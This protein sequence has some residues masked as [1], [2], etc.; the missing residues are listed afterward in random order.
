MITHLT[1]DRYRINKM[2]INTS[3]TFTRCNVNNI[4]FNKSVIHKHIK[5]QTFDWKTSDAALI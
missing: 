5:V 3:Y 2:K 1:V 4:L